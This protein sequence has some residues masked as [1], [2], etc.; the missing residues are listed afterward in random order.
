MPVIAP[1]LVGCAVDGAAV[2]R[3]GVV[4]AAATVGAAVVVDVAVELRL[5]AR[6]AHAVAISASSTA[7]MKNFMSVCLPEER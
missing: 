4:V 7:L 6:G 3:D 2:G 5:S 1:V